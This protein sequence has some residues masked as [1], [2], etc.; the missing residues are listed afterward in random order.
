LGGDDEVAVIVRPGN[1]LRRLNGLAEQLTLIPGDLGDPD[2]WRRQ[3]AGWQPEACIHAAWYAEPGLYLDSTENLS[4]LRQSL[5][6]IEELARAGCRHVVGVGTCFEYA[7]GDAPLREDSPARPATL[8][9][10]SKLAFSLVAAQRLAQLG[11]GMAWS[12]LFYIYGPYEDERRLVPSAIKALLAGREFPST[13][14]EQVRD[15][16]HVEDVASALCAQSR[17]EL[18]GVFNVCSETPVTIAGLMQTLGDL[19]GRPELIRLGAFPYR[20][21]EPM[22]VSGVNQ[23]LRTEARWSPRHTLREGLASTVDWWKGAQ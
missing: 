14:G 19:L 20:Q 1:Q 11:V 7:M 10:A 2:G 21:W 4:S 18:Q 6:L 5:E 8:Y 17:L 3:V 22:Y 15:Y 13:S 12:R 23:R 9:A 16:L